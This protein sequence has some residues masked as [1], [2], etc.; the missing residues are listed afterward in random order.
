MKSFLFTVRR[1]IV[2]ASPAVMNS[3]F[4]GNEVWRFLGIHKYEMYFVIIPRPRYQLYIEKWN[5]INILSRLKKKG[6]LYGG[7][8]MVFIIVFFFFFDK[9]ARR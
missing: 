7:N 2:C 5:K 1:A 3:A 9:V 4:A 8:E 6:Y